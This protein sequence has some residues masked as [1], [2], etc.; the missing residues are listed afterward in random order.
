MIW[1]ESK[2]CMSREQMHDLQ[3]KR[4]RKL[5]STVYHNTPFYRRKM[6]EMDITPDDIRSIDDIVKLPFTTKQD[7]RDN[8][9]F[10]LQAV[11]TSEIVRIHA[12]SGTTGN[13]TIVG[14]TRHDLE[15]WQ[16]SIARCLTAYG[17]TRNDIFSVGYGY[18]LFTGGLGAHYGAEYVGAT[19]IPTSTGNT[20]KHVRLIRDLGITG[21]ACTPSYAL[22]LAETIE[23]MGIDPQMLKLRV[24]MFGANRGQKICGKKSNPDCI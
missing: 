1:N 14:Y 16:E 12:S 3:S 11:P 2:E 4:L 17:I 5:V 10:G 9:P 22:Y 23:K 13:P 7:L 21:I 19:V 15:I 20:E 8:Y 18:G 6:Q 24:G